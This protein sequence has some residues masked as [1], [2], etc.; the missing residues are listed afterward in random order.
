MAPHLPLSVLKNDAIARTLA[1]RD[2]KIDTLLIAL[3]TLPDASVANDRL[4]N[5]DN[6]SLKLMRDDKRSALYAELLEVGVDLLN[7]L[8]LGK[9]K[10]CHVRSGDKIVGS[11]DVATLSSVRVER[12]RRGASVRTL[13]SNSA[14]SLTESAGMSLSAVE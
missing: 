9:A 8:V 6:P 1:N 3:Y 5:T 12:E 7:V 2:V 10:V 14:S 13:R 4:E 11:D